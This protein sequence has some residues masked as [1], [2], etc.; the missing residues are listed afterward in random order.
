MYVLWSMR[1]DQ[2]MQE[3][4]AFFGE[5]WRRILQE[6]PQLTTTIRPCNNGRDEVELAYDRTRGC[7]Y[8]YKDYAST[9]ERRALWP[10]GSVEELHKQHFPYRAC[11]KHLLLTPVEEYDYPPSLAA[12][13]NFI[14]GGYILST[15]LSVST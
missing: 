9:P 12:Q 14:P 13:I 6:I 1:P 15:M 2:T 7:I 3:T 8:T 11:E 10:H 5:C 4:H